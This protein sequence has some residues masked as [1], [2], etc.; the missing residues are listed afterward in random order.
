MSVVYVSIKTTCLCFPQVDDLENPALMRA[1]GLA[2]EGHMTMSRAAEEYDV[3]LNQVGSV[4]AW[5]ELRGLSQEEK[6]QVDKVR[7][8]YQH[9]RTHAHIHTLRT[10]GHP[11]WLRRWVRVPRNPHELTGLLNTERGCDSLCCFKL[12]GWG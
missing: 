9:A 11:C 6:E 4:L 10:N 2:Q 5:G 3:T 7:L 1:A 12:G 8:A